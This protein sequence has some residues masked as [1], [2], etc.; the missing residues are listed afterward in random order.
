MWDIGGQKTIRPY[1][2]NYYENTELL[3]YVVDA[4]D[5]KRTDEAGFEL[6]EILGEEKLATVPLLV[7]ANKA[8][9]L[10]VRFGAFPNPGH[11]LRSLCEYFCLLL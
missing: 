7:F 9:L 1:W 11:C 10:Q 8:D 3:I 5:R 2:R 6:D 4:S